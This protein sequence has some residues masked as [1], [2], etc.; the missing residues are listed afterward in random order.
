MLVASSVIKHAIT[1]HTFPFSVFIIY[2]QTPL[3]S[4]HTPHVLWSANP[5]NPVSYDATLHLASD[6]GLVLQ[7]VDGTIAWSTNISSDKFVAGLNL[8]DKC[9]LQLLDENN[10]TIWQSFDHPTDTLV[11]GQNLVPGQQLTS[12][13]GLFSLSLTTYGLFAYFNFYPPQPYYSY[14]FSNSYKISYAQFQ[15]E[16]FDFI[17]GNRSF[18]KIIISSS[19]YQICYIYEIWA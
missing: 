14:T 5:K 17:E 2:P 12:E 16:S 6:R 3:L 7:N 13:G 15:T 10:A 1:V 11:I 4:D 9:N 8:T 18:F 19:Q